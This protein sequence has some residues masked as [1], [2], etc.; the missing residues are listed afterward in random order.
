MQN[1]YTIMSTKDLQ[2]IA[3]DILGAK[4]EGRRAESLVPYAK[5]IYRNLNGA[6]ETV[7]LRECIEIARTDFFEEVLQRFTSDSIS[8]QTPKGEIAAKIMPDDEYI[9]ICLSLKEPG[10][11]EPGAIMEYHPEAGQIQLRVWT[12]DN[13][14]GDPNCVFQMTE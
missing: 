10:S 6:S 7:T 14:D 13:P 12:K 2:A 8:V 4:K 11:G 3:K 5:E 9:G 1:P